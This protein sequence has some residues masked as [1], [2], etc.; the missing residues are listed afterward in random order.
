M[1]QQIDDEEHNKR[2]HVAI[3]HIQVNFWRGPRHASITWKNGRPAPT[4]EETEIW[5]LQK[6]E[7]A[8]TI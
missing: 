1:L 7:K 6:E 4:N 8:E 2:W 5:S 3:V